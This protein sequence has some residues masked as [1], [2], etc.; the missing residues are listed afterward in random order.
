VRGDTREQKRWLE[1]VEEVEEK[2]GNMSLIHV[3]DREGDMSDLWSNMVERDY[4][5]VIRV[6]Y[7]RQVLPGDKSHRLFNELKNAEVIATKS[8]YLAKKDASPIPRSARVHPG[9]T[10]RKAIL[11]ISYKAVD[12]HKT[13]KH[14]HTIDETV[15]MNF[16]RVFEKNQDQKN[17]I[18]WV[19]M[20]SEPIQ[21]ADDALRVVDIY[22]GRWIIE[23]Y[24]KGLKT[25]CDLEARQLGSVQAWYKLTAMFL[26][27]T[28]RILNLCLG[29]KA[30]ALTSDQIEILKI[31][32]RR[33]GVRLRT[34]NQ[35]HSEL[36]RLGGHIK[37]NGPPGWIT[38]LR[39]YLTLIGLETGWQMRRQTM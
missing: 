36:A 28:T 19:L 14:G 29:F 39:G 2:F 38:L 10:A 16:V 5:F 15:R 22:K 18:E 12:V 31:S 27:I 1:Q 20:T 7:N 3:M 32:A 17:A 30:T 21:S 11:Q 8:V 13:N 24:F 26:P 6:K 33:A 34:P 9:R 25:G 37:T 23:E 4:R 35:A